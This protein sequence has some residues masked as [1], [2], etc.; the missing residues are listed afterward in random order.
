MTS[1][2]ID[3]Y[4]DICHTPL[5]VEPSGNSTFTVKNCSTC[6][7]DAEKEGYSKGY[8]DGFADGVKQ[9]EKTNE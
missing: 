8:S 2:N 9:A 3:L 1:I 7:R 5:K 4:C 6:W